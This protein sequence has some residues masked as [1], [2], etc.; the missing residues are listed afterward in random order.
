[1]S[2]SGSTQA[3]ELIE[4]E[5]FD[6]IILEAQ[7]PAPDGFE[8]TRFIRGSTL[9]RGVPVVMLT[10]DESIEVMRRGFKAGV[11]FFMSEPSSRE[12]VY[13]L[14]NAVRGALTQERRRHIRLPYRTKV[15]CQWGE[16]LEKRFTGESLTI[17]EGGMSVQ[18]SGGLEVGSEITLTFS[19]PEF[20][21]A[22]SPGSGRSIF[23]EKMDDRPAGKPRGVVRYRNSQDVIGI[24]FLSLPHA[25]A[26]GINR[27]ISGEEDS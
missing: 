11:T 17:G 25:M 21:P 7:M 15:V 24:E 1:M 16:N 22:K 26:E 8:L 6:G 4:K 3:Q 27:F 14:F 13:G 12:R 9:N 5:K 19:L 23:H 2:V 18:P 10:A 20:A